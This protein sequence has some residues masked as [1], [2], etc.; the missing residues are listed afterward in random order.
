M[1]ITKINLIQSIESLIEEGYEQKIINESKLPFNFNLT[2]NELKI[3]KSWYER[4][5]NVLKIHGLNRFAYRIMNSSN[6]FPYDK[7]AQIFI[8]SNFINEF[9][10]I[11]NILI[12]ALEYVE[13]NSS[14]KEIIPIT[15]D[16]I[17]NFKNY[18]IDVPIS[19]IDEK[20]TK[21]VFLEDDIEE[22]ILEI[23]GEKYKEYDSGAEMRDLST[24][25]ITLNHK[26]LKT[27]MM[28]K[29]RGI[30]TSL[31]IKDCGKN[32]DQLLKL[33][34]NTFAQ[35][36]II[37]H[38]N[39]IETEVTEALKDHLISHSAVSKIYLCEINGVDTARLLKGYGKD[40]D[41]LMNK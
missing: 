32:G 3:L 7:I 11:I 5:L 6:E 2:K 12:D 8:K 25:N 37:Q 16:D 23:I 21:S 19:S 39:K 9:S 27:V 34:K 13:V 33:A 36:Y 24:N 17:D 4:T 20:Y 31:K 41:I 35:L 30:K 10:I 18:L 15:I 28:L 40:L 1:S 29:G 22:I 26:R 38:V 14:K